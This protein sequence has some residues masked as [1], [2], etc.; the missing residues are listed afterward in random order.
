MVNRNPLYRRHSAAGIVSA[1]VVVLTVTGCSSRTTSRPSPT[2]TVAADSASSP[3]ASNSLPPPTSISPTRPPSGTA[4]PSEVVAGCRNSQITDTLRAALERADGRPGSLTKPGH[5][6]VG[7]CGTVSYAVATFQ[8]SPSA[9][10]QQQ[11]DFQDHGADPEFFIEQ[12]SD[13]WTLVGSTPGPPTPAG[14]AGCVTFSRAPQQLRSL[15]N[16]CLT[17]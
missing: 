10:S 8:P 17:V 2:P 11:V 5:T 12:G 4:T 16:N 13:S 7:V 9:T 3:A 6:Y 1:V 14:Q 15:W